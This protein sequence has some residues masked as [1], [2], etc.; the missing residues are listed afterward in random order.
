MDLWSLLR[1]RCTRTQSVSI[2]YRERCQC[3]STPNIHTDNVRFVP[4][5]YTKM[6]VGR[7]GVALERNCGVSGVG[8]EQS[9]THLVKLKMFIVWWSWR[10]KKESSPASG[11]TPPINN[12]GG[13]PLL[14]N[15]SSCQWLQKPRISA[16]GF[17]L[18]NRR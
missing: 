1:E 4:N 17:Y 6:R 13:R 8:V 2:I 18:P 12:K 7:D 3:R 10:I 14:A 16:V 11:A 9:W 5:I 15:K